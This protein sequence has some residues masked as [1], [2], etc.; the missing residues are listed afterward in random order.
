MYPTMYRNGKSS[1]QR[2]WSFRGGMA[3]VLGEMCS[4]LVGKILVVTSTFSAG[5]YVLR[6]I[7]MEKAVFEGSGALGVVAVLAGLCPELVDK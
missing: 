1:G 4:E 5:K 7:K 6:C 3:V 2:C